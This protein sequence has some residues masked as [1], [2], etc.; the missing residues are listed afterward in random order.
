LLNLVSQKSSVI[1]KQSNVLKIETI[2]GLQQIQIL[3]TSLVTLGRTETQQRQRQEQRQQQ[4]QE[5]IQLQEQRTQQK[6]KQEQKTTQE[7][8][9]I[10][11]PEEESKPKS[12]FLKKMLMKKKSNKA[13]SVFIGRGKKSKL[14][15]SGLT[16]GEALE[17]G[18]RKALQSLA[19]TFRI[20]ESGTTQKEDVGYNV[21]PQIFRGYEIKKG[22]RINTPNQFIQRMKS[23]LLTKSEKVQIKQSR[24]QFKA[25]KA[26]WF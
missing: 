4:I 21:N 9:I 25:V 10:I 22:Q 8:I 7:E 12:L 3:T 24:K 19:A 17:F 26:K 1:S 16:R 6:L 20:S 13:Y 2:T 14:V 15:A 5:Q 18:Q 23:R 11:I